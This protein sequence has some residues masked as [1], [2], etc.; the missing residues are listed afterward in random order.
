MNRAGSFWRQIARDNR[1]CPPAAEQSTCFP[2][3]QSEVLAEAAAG[4]WNRFLEQYLRPCWRE[5]VLSCRS[6]GIPLAE[7]DD[8]FQ[9][10]VVRLLREGRLN[11]VR[12]P[13][14]DR[15][16]VF[17]ANI[18]GKY[19]KYRELSLQSARFRTVL[20]SVIRNLLLESL[21]E[22]RKRPRSIGSAD[23]GVFEPAISE[24]VAAHVDRQWIAESLY[25]SAR[26][27]AAE[28]DAASTRGKRRLFDVLVRATV[29]QE[30]SAEIARSY[31]VD[32][33]TIADLLAQARARFVQILR[34]V[35]GLDDAKALQSAVLKHPE[36]LIEALARVQSSAVKSANQGG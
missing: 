15:R 19:L 7:A 14:N 10:L 26:R 20:K 36:L 31:A 5:I 25:E 17:R 1:D 22:R 8:L 27:L 2:V 24:S 32:R 12:S 30:S 29:R 33:T 16:E 34:E 13:K 28:S 21:R 18:P 6:R 4:N 9:E 3:T 11:K 35:S 23:G